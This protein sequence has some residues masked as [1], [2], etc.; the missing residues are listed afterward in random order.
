MTAAIETSDLMRVG[1]GTAMGELM[2]QYWFPAAMSSELVA[3]G[4]PIRLLLLGEK[5]IAFRDSGGRVGIMDQRCPH[6]CASLFLGR[7]EES[8]IRCVYHGWKFDVT[9]QCVDMPSVSP[10]QDFKDKVRA[11]AYPAT[12]RNG[13]IWVYMGH[14]DVAPPLPSMEASLLPESELNIWCAIRQCN[15][16]QALEG[17]IDTSHFGVLHGGHIDADDLAD[18]NMLRHTVAS[19]APDYHVG[20]SEWGTTYGAYRPAGQGQNYWRV[21]NFLFPFWCQTPAGEFSHQVDCRA[22]VPMDDE[23]TMFF[24][25]SWQQKRGQIDAHKKDG[26]PLQGLNRAVHYLPNTTDW[27]GRWRL[28]A[29]PGNDWLIDRAAQASGSIYTGIEGVHLQDQAITESMGPMTDHGFE[30]LGPSDRM[31]ARTRR[32]L[33]HAARDLRDKGVVPPGVDDP[34]VFL[35]ARSGN[36]IADA[37]KSWDEVYA[38]QVRTAQRPATPRQAAE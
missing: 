30:H 2:R 34:D 5:L 35:K 11:K 20:D 10:H 29:N 22:W 7:N 17:D 14:R 3:D 33:L 24:Q 16:M 28:A 6:R 31:V 25:L 32:R 18:D 38:E 23:H 13:L 19:R 36:F 37:G 4:P 8:G 1:P 21:A 27:Y 26:T 9:G 15:Y 12:E